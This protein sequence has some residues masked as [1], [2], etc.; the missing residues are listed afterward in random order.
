MGFEPTDSVNRRRFSKP[1]HS[2]TLA[3]LRI[4]RLL[5][6]YR[7]CLFGKT[8]QANITTA[9][10]QYLFRSFSA[11]IVILCW[12]SATPTS[13]R[14]YLASGAGDGTR[15]RTCYTQ[16]P[17]SCASTNSTTP[18]C[19]CKMR[20]WQG[21]VLPARMSFPSESNRIAHFASLCPFLSATSC[22]SIAPLGAT[23]VQHIAQPHYF[24][25]T[26]YSSNEIMLG[27]IPESRVIL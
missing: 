24:N 7:P 15:T 5:L 22:N 2:T 19:L 4:V 21:A 11:A 13:A 14:R 27:V 1:F 6:N 10:K 12:D 18:A 3:I 25:Q 16:D 9:A 20:R 23:V 17:H 26:Q 8:F